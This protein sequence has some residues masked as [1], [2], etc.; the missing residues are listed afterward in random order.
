LSTVVVAPYAQLLPRRRIDVSKARDAYTFKVYGPVPT[1][2]AGSTAAMYPGVSSLLSE[3]FGPGPGH[4]RIEVV[5]QWQNTTFETDL[6]WF[7]VPNQTHPSA[8]ATPQ[9]AV[10]GLLDQIGATMLTSFAQDQHV[11]TTTPAP[12]REAATANV[13]QTAKITHLTPEL[14]AQLVSLDTCVWVGRISVPANLQ[15]KRLRLMLRE[16]ERHLSDQEVVVQPF[17]FHQ[18]KVVERLVFA[19]EFPLAPAIT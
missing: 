13:A 8:D 17:P 12:S 5:L 4:N 7:D 19:R 10:L 14:I 15:G 1:Q 9:Q 2:G 16:Y 11:A 3:Y 18:P 6:D